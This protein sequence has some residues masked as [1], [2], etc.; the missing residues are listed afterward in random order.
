MD[1]IDAMEQQ[2]NKK[3]TGCPTKKICYKYLLGVKVCFTSFHI[4]G[5]VMQKI[6]SK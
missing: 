3:T 1:D 6:H 4:A 2:L 5:T